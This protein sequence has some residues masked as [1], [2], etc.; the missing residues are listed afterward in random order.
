MTKKQNHLSIVGKAGCFPFKWFRINFQWFVINSKLVLNVFVISVRFIPRYFFPKVFI[1]SFLLIKCDLNFADGIQQLQIPAES[2]TWIWGVLLCCCPAEY[3]FL[4][5]L[6]SFVARSI[7]KVSGVAAL[8][9][10]C[11]DCSGAA[12]IGSIPCLNLNF[13]IPCEL[14]PMK[15]ATI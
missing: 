10:A 1:H 13:E 4:L 6:N 3:L 2:A 9:C 11:L 7:S 15:V 5:V 8:I 14:Q 12:F